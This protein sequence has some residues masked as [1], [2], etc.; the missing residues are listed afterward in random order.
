MISLPHIQ[1]LIDFAFFITIVLL[2]CQLNK[3]MVKQ[4][5]PVDKKA[6]GELH[7]IISD[8]QEYVNHFLKAVEENETAMNKLI[9]QLDSKEQKLIMLIEQAEA[10][11][12]KSDS[13]KT[14][15]EPI[16]SSEKYDDILKMI[17]QGLSREVVAKRSGLTEGEINLVVEL[18]HARAGRV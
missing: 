17:Q 9:R 15:S 10:L 18:A 2:L 16:S 14:A 6:V 4:P 5:P 11:T 13:R 7:K 12:Q 3:R 1:I 8:S